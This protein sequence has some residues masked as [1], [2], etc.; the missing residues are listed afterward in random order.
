MSKSTHQDTVL[1]LLQALRLSARA[2]LCCFKKAQYW[3]LMGVSKTQ[4]AR[5][6]C[7]GE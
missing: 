4:R 1:V 7:L 6:L 5:E 2:V 3:Y